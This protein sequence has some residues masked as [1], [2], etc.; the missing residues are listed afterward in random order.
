MKHVLATVATNSF[1]PGTLVTLHSFRRFNPWFTGR[2]VVIHSGLR[3][4]NRKLLQAL[5][6]SVS[7]VTPHR[8]LRDSVER[9]TSAKTYLKGR[10]ARFYS[11]EASRIDGCDRL[12]F[13]DSDTLIQAD[14]RELFE[15][16]S[17]M[18]ACGERIYY[19]GQGRC[20]TTMVP[21][22]PDDDGVLFPTINGG[23]WSLCGSVLGEPLYQR[24]LSW[25]EVTRWGEVQAKLTDQILL[26]W[27]YATLSTELLSGEFNYLVSYAK[28]MGECRSLSSSRIVHFAGPGKPWRLDTAVTKEVRNPIFQMASRNW[29]KEYHRVVSAL[30]FSSVELTENGNG[31]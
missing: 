21:R 26:N 9:L 2:I 3:L 17:E 28:E 23:V 20:S 5:F 10:G 24:L 14:I 31:E 12:V 29:R 7:F 13:L 18:A 30:H 8:D 19:R 11:V 22:D 25:M 1:F 6:G 27:L 4:E 15:S 16:Q